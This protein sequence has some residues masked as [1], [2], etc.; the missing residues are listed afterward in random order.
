MEK[1]GIKTFCEEYSKRIDSLK[2]QYIKDNL[3]ITPYIPY[4][5]KG[6]L[7]DS[8][9]K[10]TMVDEDGNVRVNSYV[11]YLLLTR[12]FIEQY[13]NLE[14]ETEGFFEEYDALKKS[15]LFN[16][17]FI[18]TDDKLPLIPYAEIEEF[19]FIINE[20]K[21]DIM[22]NKYE[23]HSFI[24]EQVERFGKL[25]NV[26]LNPIV[27]AVSKLIE[28][29]PEEDINNVIE[30]VKRTDFREDKSEESEK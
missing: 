22:T 24:K 14:V 2:E 26:T 20:K 28:D 21:K 25:A 29:V 15:G 27:D 8:L 19:K 3:K 9:L 12:I 23:I 6:S 11:E 30:F 10:I 16:L 13:T 18:G 17:L 7:A 5:V 4:V 1:I